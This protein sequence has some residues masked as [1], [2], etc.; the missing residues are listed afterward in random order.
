MNISVLVGLYNNLG[1]SQQ[2]YQYFRKIYPN[3][4]LVFV[5]YGSN[6]GTHE[7][8]EEI[9]LK[10]SKLIIYSESIKKTF[11]DTYNKAAELATSEYIV[12]CHNDI[13]VAPNWLETLSE[14]LSLNNVVGYT[15]IEP[16]IFAGHNRPGKFIKDFGNDFD[17]FEFDNFK[18]YCEKHIKENHGRI[19]NDIDFFISLNRKFFLKIGGFDNKFNPY[20]YEDRDL[21]RR[22]KLA[23]LNTFTLCDSLVYHF[24]SKTSRFSEEAK[25]KT[26]QIETN[27]QRTYIR[28]WGSYES[29]NMFNIGFNI[30]NA[31]YNIIYHLEP[32]CSTIHT[33][34][35]D[36]HKY[37]EN[38][39]EKTW[40]DL[41]TKFISREEFDS[42]TGVIIKFDASKL[43]QQRFEFLQ[44]IQN[45]LGEIEEEGEYEFDIFR[46]IVKDLTNSIMHNIYI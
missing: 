40:F 21:I 44:N 18:Q 5:S 9:K 37:V 32:W 36:Y 7:W 6:D 31:D 19:E 13:V 38:E 34:Y 45:I 12:F 2:F 24:V 26:T 4:E 10:D 8:L 25:S 46:I 30:T 22:L 42:I 39:Q 41:Q 16:S 17:D 1:Y 43:T 14:N 27:S 11:S 33:D 35:S 3:V 23:G 29:E 15:T 28:K 20:F